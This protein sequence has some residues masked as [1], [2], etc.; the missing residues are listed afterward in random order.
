MYFFFSQFNEN[1]HSYTRTILDYTIMISV[2]IIVFIFGNIDY[3]P[4][5]N[6]IEAP[7]LV[8]GHGNNFS[9]FFITSKEVEPPSRK[10][11][12]YNLALRRMNESIIGNLIT[13]LTLG[14]CVYLVINLLV[15][16]IRNLL[17]VDLIEAGI[18]I[19][20]NKRGFPEIQF[21]DLVTK[22][23]IVCQ[24]Q[25]LYH[26]KGRMIG[27][28]GVI[29]MHNERMARLR[30]NF[31][32]KKTKNKSKGTRRRSKSAEK[33]DLGGFGYSRK[34]TAGGST[35]YE[36]CFMTTSS[37]DYR[38]HPDFKQ[39]FIKRMMTQIVT[40][41]SKEDAREKEMRRKVFK[42]GVFSQ[43][44][45][46]SST[47]KQGS[48]ISIEHRKRGESGQRGENNQKGESQRRNMTSVAESNQKKPLFS[49]GGLF[50]QTEKGEDNNQQKPRKKELASSSRKLKEVSGLIIPKN[51]RKR[52][53][54]SSDFSE[55]ND[56]QNLEEI[57][58]DQQKSKNKHENNKNN[59]LKVEEDV[60]H[61]NQTQTQTIIRSI[62]K[63]KVSRT[64]QTV[65]VTIKIDTTREEKTKT[66]IKK[67]ASL[68]SRFRGY[69][70]MAGLMMSPKKKTKII[71]N[72]REFTE[73]PVGFLDE[74][75]FEEEVDE[76]VQE[77]EFSRKM[78]TYKNSEMEISE[79]EFDSGVDSDELG[80]EEMGLKKKNN[81]RKN[82]FVSKKSRFFANEKNEHGQ[83]DE[84]AQYIENIFGGFEQ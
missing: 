57:Q 55:E 9:V 74:V 14:Y 33:S 54:L 83:V 78:S 80:G 3:F 82:G 46:K 31:K 1:L 47:N 16:T 73:Y 67:K 12:L 39:M 38:L 56:P 18:E 26:N 48:N 2:G 10:P 76:S 52:N 59:Q 61:Q 72:I 6:F 49:L 40:K 35:Y 45:Q 42:G 41:V 58:Q 36:K 30:R 21:E 32:R 69:V 15:G 50:G 22:T 11:N 24:S 44:I 66:T 71:K 77:A 43:I 51:D 62:S 17:K 68:S 4:E 60:Q 65:S 29:K 84:D 7:K 20:A 75:Y 64:N 5:N 53:K 34:T 27:G 63:E 13:M 19:F 8:A 37:Y 23:E 28:E 25:I 79:E 81:P 70:N